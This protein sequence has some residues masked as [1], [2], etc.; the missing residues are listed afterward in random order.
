MLAI[1]C[2]LAATTLILRASAQEATFSD[3]SKLDSIL[4]R[5]VTT[6]DRNN[7]RIIDLLADDTGRVQA[8]VVEFGGFLGIGTRKIAVHWSALRFENAKVEVDITADEL[9]R[10]PEY[11]FNVTPILVGSPQQQ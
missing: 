9:R 5:E 10:A 4:G 3:T 1:I 6:E 7:G 11:K 8:A 2:T